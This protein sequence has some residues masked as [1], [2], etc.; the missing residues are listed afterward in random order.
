VAIVSA[1][2]KRSV[3]KM[4]FSGGNHLHRKKV[5]SSSS[6]VGRSGRHGHHH[7]HH[8]HSERYSDAHGR[9]YYFDRYGVVLGAEAS[10]RHTSTTT[11]HLST[12]PLSS[13]LDVSGQ[14]HRARRPP[15]EDVKAAANDDSFDPRK[16][17][18]E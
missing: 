12:P 11:P 15:K 17:V 5:S 7:H 16:E 18:S 14:H 6:T 4:M 1:E 13:A 9:Q 8:H 10:P 2:T 3:F